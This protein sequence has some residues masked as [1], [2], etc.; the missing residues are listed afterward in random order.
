M[1]SEATGGTR[2]DHSAH[3]CGI[4]EQVRIEQG[5]RRNGKMS[6]RAPTRRRSRLGSFPFLADRI[7]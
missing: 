4:V 2:P 3:P 7:Q 1:G 5:S 6:L